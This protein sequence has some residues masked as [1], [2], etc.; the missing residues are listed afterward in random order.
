MKN[1]LK[2]QTK[3]ANELVLAEKAFTQMLKKNYTIGSLSRGSR[4]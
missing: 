3:T 4:V 1:G 2:N